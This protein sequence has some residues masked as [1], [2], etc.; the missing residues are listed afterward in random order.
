MTDYPKKPRVWLVEDSEADELLMR[1]A[2]HLD[3]LDCDF[4]VSV[5]GE[6]A[7]EFLDALDN[8]RIL[9]PV[10][11]VV[12]LDLNLPR[13][14]G[15]KVLERIRQ[16]PFCGSTP[17]IIVSSSDSSRDRTQVSHLG[18]TQYFQKPLDLTEFM[19][20]GPLVREVLDSRHPAPVVARS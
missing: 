17:V 8:G 11:N 2:L 1:A 6:K 12:L 5:D 4:Q 9:P 20:L 15:A 16:S 19:K 14:G 3:G 13:K 10:P 18:A 7:M